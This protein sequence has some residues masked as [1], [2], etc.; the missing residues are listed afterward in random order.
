[1]E[2]FKK[3]GTII[4]QKVLKKEVNNSTIEYRVFVICNELISKYEYY[5]VGDT[6][7]TQ[8]SN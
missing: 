5:E 3:I 1:M 7:D 6:I 4:S 8:S 2:K